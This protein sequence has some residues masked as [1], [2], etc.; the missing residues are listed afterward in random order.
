MERAWA[1]DN[2]DAIFRLKIQFGTSL[3]Y[4]ISSMGAHDE[5]L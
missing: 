4:A 3:V 1:S 5:N 2:T